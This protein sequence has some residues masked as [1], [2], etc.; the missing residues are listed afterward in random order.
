MAESILKTDEIRLLNNQVLMSDGALTGNV[1]MSNITLAANHA[2]VKTALN[3][4]GDAP[5][6]ACRAWCTLI[7]P[8]ILNSH[9]ATGISAH[10][11]I[12]S[13]K[14]LGTGRYEI[15]MNQAMVDEHYCVLVTAKDSSLGQGNGTR[16]QVAYTTHTNTTFTVEFWGWTGNSYEPTQVFI[17]VFR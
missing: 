4:S 10:G 3:A 13:V 14:E 9:S 17:A 7:G 12:S 11:N 2:G 8:D 15:T 6:Y 16:S 1:D 5:I